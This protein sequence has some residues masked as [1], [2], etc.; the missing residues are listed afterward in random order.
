MKR[1]RFSVGLATVCL[2]AMLLAGAGCK[3]SSESGPGGE[4]A[5]S[6]GNTPA[7]PAPQACGMTGGL[8]E[9]PART[10]PPFLGG[11]PA[12]FVENYGIYFEQATAKITRADQS[13]ALL[14]EYD[15]PPAQSWGNWLSFRRE[16]S[17]KV[18]LTGCTGLEVEIRIERPSDARLRLTLCD[19]SSPADRSDEMWWFDFPRGTL[20]K[21]GDSFIL[22]APFSGFGISYGGG[23]R[24]NDGKLDLTRI[25]A[26]E[27]NVLSAPGEHPTG[28]FLLRA[29]RAYGD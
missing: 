29:V 5:A 15:V 2:C 21:T 20:S 25:T 7:I 13:G 26:Y 4:V 3:R 10:L 14:F 23:T 17:Q 1:F 24:Q 19:V 16:F 28:A 9:L 18:D 8:H 22:R 6:G 11:P 12:N 27:I